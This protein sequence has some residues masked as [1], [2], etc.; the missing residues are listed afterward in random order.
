MNGL[1]KR[2]IFNRDS[3]CLLCYTFVLATGIHENIRTAT[4][5]VAKN[6]F[7]I[8]PWQNRY[9]TITTIVL[10][11]FLCF[12]LGVLLVLGKICKVIIA[13]FVREKNWKFAINFSPGS[14]TLVPCMGV[15][16]FAHPQIEDEVYGSFSNNRIKWLSC[17]INV[18]AK[19]QNMICDQAKQWTRV[20]L[21]DSFFLCQSMSLW[22]IN[23]FD[24]GVSFASYPVWVDDSGF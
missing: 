23:Q 24:H 12:S 2:I 10:F 16:L 5:H 6:D 19:R 17:C 15:L 7:Q 3:V 9:C 11:C 18:I 20:V 14:V 22:S 1:A 21:C 13:L 8:A 4:T